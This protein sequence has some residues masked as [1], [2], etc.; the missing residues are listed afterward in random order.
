MKNMLDANDV[1][2]KGTIDGKFLEVAK[3][4]TEQIAILRGEV[5]NFRDNFTNF[6]HA[7]AQKT[8]AIETDHINL[9]VNRVTPL[10]GVIE[11]IKGGIEAAVTAKLAEV[12]V[13][14]QNRMSQMRT[15]SGQREYNREKPIM[16]YKAITEGLSKLTKDKSGSGAGK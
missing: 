9:D 11:R 4:Y 5:G 3:G 12:D 13:E 8:A 10:E 1:V 16:E 14:I 15:G 7:T 6:R 2:L